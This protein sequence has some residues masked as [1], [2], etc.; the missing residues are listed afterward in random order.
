RNDQDLIMIAKSMS[1]H[2]SPSE[3]PAA[4]SGAIARARRVLDQTLGYVDPGVRPPPDAQA[5]GNLIVG[6]E[7]SDGNLP[8]RGQAGPELD[9]DRPGPARTR[10]FRAAARLVRPRTTGEL[11]HQWTPGLA[12]TRHLHGGS[13]PGHHPGDLRL[14]LEPGHGWPPP[15]GQG[16]ARAVRA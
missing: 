14:P 15:H 4:G 9:A 7:K 8:P 6:K 3:Y 12:L 11:W 5:L 16:H 1:H 2:S 10:V 13:H